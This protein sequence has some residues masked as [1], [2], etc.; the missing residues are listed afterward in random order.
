MRARHASAP[1]AVS[2]L[3][4]VSLVGLLGLIVEQMR[5]RA[6]LA[7]NDGRVVLLLGALER[8]E[9][10]FVALDAPLQRGVS[11][12]ILGPPS[13]P[14]WRAR[15]S[16]WPTSRQIRT[17]FDSSAPRWTTRWAGARATD[18]VTSPTVRR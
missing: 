11:V 7:S 18:I 3:L 2:M 9:R 10:R 6:E 15:L 17:S 14:E 1:G 4:A 16:A 13:G 8:Q 5:L 12:T